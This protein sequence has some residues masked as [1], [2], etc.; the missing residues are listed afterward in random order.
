MKI[1]KLFGVVINL[2][3][4]VY[5]C[6]PPTE[7]NQSVFC[8]ARYVLTGVVLSSRLTSEEAVFQI[9]VTSNIKGIIAR[10]GSKVTLYGSGTSEPCGPTLLKNNQKYLI[11]V[12]WI[13][14]APNKLQVAEYT[15]PSTNKIRKFKNYD[16]S[17]EIQI[18][19]SWNPASGPPASPRDTCVIRDQEFDCNFDEGFC[20]R[21]PAYPYGPKVCQW[22]APQTPCTPRG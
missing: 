18:D 4:C 11:Y 6:D 15:D 13:S 20:A 14:R 8:R 21:R 3:L 10:P 17:C 7:S 16:C 22:I 12:G 5:S 2:S 19:L 9:K 1:L